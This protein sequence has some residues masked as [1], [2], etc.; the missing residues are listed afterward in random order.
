MLNKREQSQVNKSSV[1]K[2]QL[3]EDFK[4][5]ANIGVKK[6]GK[7]GVST[8]LKSEKTADGRTFAIVQEN[9]DY[10]IKYTDK[11]DAISATDLKYIGGAENRGKIDKFDS[12]QRA[13]NRLTLICESLNKKLLKEGKFEKPYDEVEAP[14]DTTGEVDDL[15]DEDVTDSEGNKTDDEIDLDGETD[16]T[17]TTLDIKS[18]DSTDPSTD[19]VS[20]DEI[21]SDGTEQDLLNDLDS[22]TQTEP[23]TEMPM[24]DTSAPSPEGGTDPLGD[25]ILGDMGGDQTM[26]TDTSNPVDS[27]MPELGPDATNPDDM[28]GDPT[29][30][31]SQDGNPEG[32]EDNAKKEFQ[33]TVGSLGQSINSLKDTNQFDEKDIKNVMNSL[34]TAIGDAFANIDETEKEKF[35]ERIRKNGEELKDDEGGEEKTDPTKSEVPAKAPVEKTEEPK[36]KL[37]EKFLRHLKKESVKILSEEAKKMVIEKQRKQLIESI[38]K[39]LK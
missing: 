23:S 29:M 4:R 7:T 39:L 19:T 31:D 21:T 25:D 22:E 1:T 11:K 33:K 2:E 13:S 32:G 9:K 14:V 28:G 36:E 34:I 30:T 24:G 3:V 12:F 38:T 8:I 18:D 16:D 20:S 10:Y 35:F 26:P 27:A 37:D 6:T 5:L 15:G 17:S